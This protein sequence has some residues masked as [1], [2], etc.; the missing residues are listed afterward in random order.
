MVVMQDWSHYSAYILVQKPD[1][2]FCPPGSVVLPYDHPVIYRYDPTV[3]L[4][5][6]SKHPWIL[7]QH[8]Q[9][10]N[11]RLALMYDKEFLGYDI[12][13][14]ANGK[15]NYIASFSQ[16][17]NFSCIG[18][19]CNAPNACWMKY[20]SQLTVNNQATDNTFLYWYTNCQWCQ[21]PVLLH[22]IHD[23]IN[24][25]LLVTTCFGTQVR[26]SGSFLILVCKVKGK[27]IGLELL[28]G[29]TF[30]CYFHLAMRVAE[31]D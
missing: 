12:A 11:C 8:S 19:V 2:N 23:A 28:A 22:K 5:T 15:M 31:W 16:C 25:S 4:I 26:L 18:L 27:N 1:P 17:L 21:T 10:K 30:K 6:C 24:T 7:K 9:K 14:F 20:A 29:A 3:T 13:A